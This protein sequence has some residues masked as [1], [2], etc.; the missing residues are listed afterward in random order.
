MFEFI[1]SFFRD[2]YMIREGCSRLINAD[3]ATDVVKLSEKFERQ[4][5]IERAFRMVDQ[6]RTDCQTRN[7]SV[8]L[9]LLSLCLKIK[10]FSK[11]KAR[12]LDGK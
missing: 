4:N 8:K 2:M 10:G 11:A 6:V 9:A 7:A 1:T 3:A 12:R 5:T